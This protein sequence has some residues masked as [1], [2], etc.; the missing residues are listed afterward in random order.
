MT[1]KIDLRLMNSDLRR[2]GITPDE[3]MKLACTVV[4]KAVSTRLSGIVQVGFNPEDISEE[5]PKGLRAH[6]PKEWN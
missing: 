2:A 6:T 3:L 1:G 5:D 4:A